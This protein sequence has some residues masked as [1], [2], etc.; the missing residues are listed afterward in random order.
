MG[1]GGG[2]RGGGSGGGGATGGGHALLLLSSLRKHQVTAKHL[3]PL[4][5][6]EGVGALN[7]LLVHTHR[8]C[9]RVSNFGQMHA[10]RGLGEGKW[11]VAVCRGCDGRYL[12]GDILVIDRR[13]LR[14]AVAG[15]GG[16][17]AAAAVP[18]AAEEEEAAATV[19]AVTATSNG[20]KPATSKPAAKPRSRGWASSAALRRWRRLHAA[21]LPL[22]KHLP[23]LL[24][25]HLASQLPL[26]IWFAAVVQP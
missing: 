20:A 13:R 15:L 3:G 9:H 22:Q 1:G 14:L 7:R 11:C 17:P 10:G 6:I 19:T 4:Q 12:H 5:G 18:V 8:P 23:L 25:A 24:H 2:G 16:A 26:P 21:V